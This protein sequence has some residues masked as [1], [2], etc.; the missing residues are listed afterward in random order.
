MGGELGE[1]RESMRATWLALRPFTGRR[2]SR[3]VAVVAAEA[4]AAGLLEAALLVAVVTVAVSVARDTSVARV[5]VAQLNT[6]SLTAGQLLIAAASAGMVMLALH[7]HIARLSSQLSASVLQHTRDAVIDAFGRASWAQQSKEREGSLQETVST[8]A[9]N[10]SLL[11]TYLITV[12][13]SAAGLGALLAASCVVDPIATVVVLVFGAAL[14]TALRPLNR[15]I[16]RRASQYVDRNTEFVERISEWSSLAMEIRAFGG[17]RAEAERQ[18]TRNQAVARAVARARFAARFG[19]DLYRDLVIMAM[20]AAVAALYVANG[21]RLAALGAVVML[22]V[23]ALSYA[24]NA[25]ASLQQV[26]ELAPNLRS[27]VSRLERLRRAE[28]QYGTL[29]FDDFVRIDFQAVG[30]DYEPGRVGID[31][32]NLSIS[33]GEALGIVGPSGAGKSTLVQVLLR[34]REPTRGV[35]LV[36]GVPY[37]EVASDS[38]HRLVAFVPQEP[39]LFRGTV[40][41]N[42]AFLRPH[43]TRADVERAA[44]QA[45]VL[46]DILALP[47]GFD[48]ELGPRGAGLSGG[49]KQRVAIARA[50]AGNPSLLVLDE[51]TSALDP[52]SEALLQSTIESLKGSVALVIVAHRLTT[53]APC[54][55]VV[56]MQ[57]GR[58]RLVGTLGEAVDAV[59]LNM[60][61]NLPAPAE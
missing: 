36:S 21:V 60:E 47:D 2:G 43:I 31:D 59:H 20:I 50:L 13:A 55:R 45:R 37:Q 9:G 53:L 48:T 17:T 41:E 18:H 52:R 57:D 32:I 28:V 7:V 34:I 4:L 61:S 3:I 54:D 40:A 35:V 29:S 27:F 5:S 24:Q 25:N 26:R 39:K 33:R 58:V 6:L 10:S 16:S 22:I 46:D 51:P 15:L 11:V 49:Q 14:A 44:Q 8:L 23:R 56:A 12:T 38:W 1:P 30:Y 19:A 42:I